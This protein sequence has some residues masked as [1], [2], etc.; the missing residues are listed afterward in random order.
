MILC[1]VVLDFLFPLRL[2]NRPWSTLVLAGDG[3]PLRAFADDN[4]IWRYPTDPASVSPL[5]IQALLTYEDRWFHYHPGVNPFAFFRALIQNISAGRIVSGGSTLTMQVARILYPNRRTPAG[6]MTQILRAFQLEA[7]LSKNEILSLYLNYAPFG[8]NIE[9]VQTASY[10]WLGKKADRLSHAQAALLAVLPQA[11]SF[12]RPDRHPERARMARDKVL[13]RMAEFRVWSPEQVQ[14]A[15]QEAVTAFR[16]HQPLDAPILA[17]RLFFSARDRTLVHTTIDYDLQ[18]HLQQMV[19]EYAATLGEHQSG[20]VMVMN[21]QTLEVAA[22]VGSSDFASKDRNGH[23][24][25]IRAVRSPGSTLKPFLY[26]MAL[27]EGIIHSHSLLM[28]TPR[29]RK[30]YTPGNFSRGFSGPVSMA[31]ALR[32]S[33]NVPAVQ[34]LEAFG[35]QTFH[36]RLVNAGAALDLSGRPNLSMV[37]GGLGT[38]L[39]STLVLYSALARDGLTGMPR[40]LKS[41]PVRERYLMSEG[42]AWIISRILSQPM[43][44]FEGISRLSGRTPMAWKTGTS[45][46]FR[47]AW[48]FGIM[49]DYVAGVW[50]GRPDGTPCPGQY[51]A[52]TAIPL[53]QSV[54]ESLPMSDFRKKQPGSVTLEKICWPSGTLKSRTKETCF[55]THD[56][57]ILDHQVPLTLNPDDA[58]AATLSHTFWVDARGRRA[59]PSCGGINTVARSVWPAAAEPWLPRSWKA[60]NII[61]D[62]SPDCPDIAPLTGTR[63]HITSIFPGSVI[64]RPPG[65][66]AVPD[67]PLSALGGSGRLHWFLNGEPVAVHPAG[68]TGAIALPSPGAYQLAVAD[69]K[70]HVDMVRFT[71]LSLD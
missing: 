61:P 28:D 68:S 24:D 15:K 49:G 35:P 42:A 51:G 53:L 57:W 66:T 62:A 5:Y 10:T 13:D 14:A 20:A 16:F 52:V 39:E 46:G 9:G 47:D 38:S 26:G 59:R 31:Q 48:A 43:P 11:P 65:Q 23:V 70:G 40:L 56:A 17:R 1:L 12:Y 8:A 18:R 69:D 36:D 25:M 37:L 30:E 58:P 7:H 4:G 45:Y 41:D 27:D 33:L 60:E 21:L 54:F 6:K 44:G 34:V 55:V 50:V 19:M 67:I 2:E 22:Y 63:I 64:S 32:H 71:V 29:F 3:T